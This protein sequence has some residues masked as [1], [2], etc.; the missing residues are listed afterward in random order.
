MS[1]IMK[2]KNLRT[3]IFLDS[4]DPLETKKAIDLL[5]FLDGQTTNPTLLAKNPIVV[6]RIK[7]G[8]KFSKDE[9]Y[10]LYKAIAREIS[11]HIPE[12]SVS[13]EVYADLETS[14]SHM[15]EEARELFSW[16]PNAHIKLPCIPEGI[17][18]AH[19]AIQ[20]NMRVNMTLCFTQEQAHAVFLATRGAKRGE[21]FVSPFIGRLDDIGQNGLSLVSNI[22][23]AYRMSQDTHVEVL[24]A[25]VRNI[26]HFL[27]C[28]SMRCDTITAPFSVLTEWV[29]RKC[30]VP[31]ASYVYNTPLK[32]I[33]F[34]RPSS[35]A[36]DWKTMRFE[37]ELIKPGI[38]KFCTDWKNLI[39]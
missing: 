17:K 4:G 39:A 15:L 16:I 21:V 36:D 32:T 18:A 1:S 24:A 3:K 38:E 7:K 37:H 22:L 20:E 29:R 35:F 11:K 28:L 23:E 9:V 14:S 13:L 26:D 25:S 10:V 12:G 6:E 31:D 27:A 2:P 19:Q 34:K 33:L 30:Y 5:G 8:E